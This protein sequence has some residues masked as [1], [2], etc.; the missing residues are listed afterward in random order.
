MRVSA[1]SPWVPP[2]GISEISSWKWSAW[3]PPLPFAGGRRLSSGPKG[4]KHNHIRYGSEADTA[5][6]ERPPGRQSLQKTPLD[7]RQSTGALRQ[8][9][10]G[11]KGEARVH[12]RS[13]RSDLQCLIKNFRKKYLLMCLRCDFRHGIGPFVAPPK[14]PSNVTAR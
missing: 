13:A 7:A 9:R 10:A 14:A 11:S 6:A 3:L 8:A 4:N 12:L 5:K 2:H 1:V